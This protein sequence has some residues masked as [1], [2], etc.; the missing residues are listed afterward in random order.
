[1]K[2]SNGILLI[3]TIML[4][5]TSAHAAKMYRWVDKDGNVHYSD[6]VPPE[7]AQ[8]ERKVLNEQGVET[9]KL[10][11]QLTDE[12]I[13]E[14]N[15]LAAEEEAKQR[16]VDER[17]KRDEMLRQSYTTVAEMENAR[18]G[19]ITAIESQILVT[20]RSIDTLEQRL[21]GTEAQAKRLNDG[22]KEVPPNLRQQIDKT[23]AELLENQKFLMA[24]RAE[25]EKIR[26]EFNEDIARF[27]EITG[28]Q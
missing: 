26:G 22:G 1:M 10:D 19:R 17:N 27:K 5:A 21:S 14:K 11:R 16:V 9:E 12:E 13:A 7:A 24:R 25:Q 28:R 15:R 2:H 4:L 6:K 23:R 3:L 20:S 18:D 8:Q